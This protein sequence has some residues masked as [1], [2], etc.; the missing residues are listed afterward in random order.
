M[1]LHNDGL[2][3]PSSDAGAP[4][5]LG[6]D[7][8]TAPALLQD[9]FLQRASNVYT[10]EQ[11]LATGRPALATKGVTDQAAHSVFSTRATHWY[12][13]QGKECAI[14]LRGGT[15][16]EADVLAGTS[17]PIAG[18]T[19]TDAATYRP[20]LAQLVNTAFRVMD[21]GAAGLAWHRYSGGAWVNGTVA[22]FSD[23][24][25]MPVF[26]E[27]CAHRFRLFAAVKGTDTLYA[28]A[29]LD[30]ELPANWL[31]LNTTRIGDGDADPI[32]ALHPF[33]ES[34]LLVLKEASVWLLDTAEID[35]ANWSMRR[36]TGLV[37]CAEPHTV[38]QIGQDV[39]FMSRYGVVSVGALAQQNSVS[40][41]ETVSAPIDIALRTGRAAWATRFREFFILAWDST[42]AATGGAADKFYVFNTRQKA[43]CGEWS[44]VFPDVALSGARTAVF[45][46]WTAATLV[47]PGAVENTMLTDSCGR[48]ALFDPTAA[49]DTHGAGAQDIPQEI[50]TKS[51]GFDEPSNWKRAMRLELT[52]HRQ[53]VAT[54]T[55]QLVLDGETTPVTIA[56]DVAAVNAA[57]FPITFPFSFFGRTRTGD[58]RNLLPLV[59]RR[60]REAAVR[61]TTGG[62][63]ALSLRA[64]KISVLPD[65]APMTGGAL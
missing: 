53:S 12:D 14:V 24:S 17:A 60:F 27:V 16:F 26:G 32:V 43:W 6:V 31:K 46:G 59:K 48:F 8:T 10:D 1:R 63:G 38:V 21:A 62:S 52:F 50:I 37:G 36:L 13:A 30:A 19:Y 61:I 4:G 3:D 18:A 23:A 55:V 25:A 54:Y 58:V 35:P 42:G 5:F 11:G 33:Q 40:P 49:T 47:R 51:Y 15:I 44:A 64:V 41:A 28:S 39:L 2:D 22:T 9:A 56:A 20:K 65:T 34:L 7:M 29:Y 57:S 45:S